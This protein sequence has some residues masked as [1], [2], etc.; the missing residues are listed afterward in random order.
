MT[1]GH[2][3]SRDMIHWTQL[4]NKLEPDQMGTMFSGS[5]IVDWNNTS[6]LQQGGEKPLV[7]LYTA[8]GGTSDASKGKKFTQCLAY[9]S[10]GG[11][12]WK[13]YDKNPVLGHIRAE[14]RDPKVIWH[15]AT[16]KWIMALYLD[17]ADFT[18]YSSPDLK[19]WTHLHDLA[20]EGTG[21]CPDFFPMKV[22]GEPNEE[23]WVWTAANGNYLVGAF[24]GTRFTP[25]SKKSIRMDYGKNYYAVQTFSDIPDSDG[26]RIQIAWMREGRYPRMPFNQQMSIP[27][28]LRL[29]RTPEGLRLYNL[30]IKEVE[31][32][33]SSHTRVWGDVALKPG[34][35][36]LDGLRGD[37]FDIRAE[38]DP[39][40]AEEFGFR[41]R[42]EP[43]T[44]NVK[45]K[46]INTGVLGSAPLELENGRIS[47]RILVDRTSLEIFG[48]E[49]RVSLSSCFLPPPD[50]TILETFAKGGQARIRHMEIRE[51]KS[52]WP[53]P[54]APAP[55]PKE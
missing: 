19:T 42:G 45:S 15:E 38:I 23:R 12:T 13:K 32:L 1:W 31:W 9:S 53:E 25:E 24:D 55:A 37:L 40:K 20:V 8:A 43:V 29:K 36:L 27:R 46:Q 33:Y 10:D 16:K 54:A 26:R 6:G 17:K 35:N 18:F 22:V 21:E 28:E 5:A 7:I 34:E 49:G 4:E 39:G 30:P 3:V 47:L 50:N 2:A 51:L 41:I 48:N 44:Y 52:A 14:N 11:K